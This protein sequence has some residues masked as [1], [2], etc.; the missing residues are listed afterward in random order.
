MTSCG[1]VSI[2]AVDT[3]A[4]VGLQLVQ[5][6]E[7]DLM[8]GVLAKEIETY[9]EHRDT[10]LATAEG[11]FVLIKG[12]EVVGTFECEKDAIEE[13]YRR[14]GNVPFLVRKIERIETPLIFLSGLLAV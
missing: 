6:R 2:P 10:F 4:T 8:R 14:F 12:D 5:R 13:G 11:R 3:F 7:I 1:A 9:E